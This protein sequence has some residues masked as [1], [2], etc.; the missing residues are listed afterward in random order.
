MHIQL[1]VRKSNVLK[2]VWHAAQVP[3]N[4][5]VDIGRRISI[6]FPFYKKWYDGVINDYEPRA[7]PFEI[8]FGDGEFHWLDLKQKEINGSR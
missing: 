1:C 7:K 3:A 6:Y 4:K 5:H 2:P 8:E